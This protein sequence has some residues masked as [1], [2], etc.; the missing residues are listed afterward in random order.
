MSKLV[1]REKTEAELKPEPPMCFPI[2]AGFLAKKI[3]RIYLVS[4][5]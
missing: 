2:L 4:E 5:L 1:K 3:G